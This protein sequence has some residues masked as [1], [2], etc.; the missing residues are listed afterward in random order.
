MSRAIATIARRLCALLVA[1]SVCNA[2]LAG[3]TCSVGAT[4]VNFGTYDP[5]LGS[6][7]DSTGTISV[8]CSI[9][10]PPFVE[11]VGYTVELSAGTGTYA[12]RRMQ[13]GVNQLFYNLYTDLP[14]TQI[15]GNGSG[16]TSDV[17]SSMTIGFF[18]WP[19]TRTNT[20]TLYGRIPP[21]QDIAP[22]T[23]T[24]TIVVT[25]TY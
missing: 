9:T 19:S 2:A 10:Y 1:G 24:D 7:L 5:L 15:W 13:S 22:G 6:A 16:G 3:V 20:H 21:A 25:V 14:R 4:G 18:F 23:Y 17:T 11:N 12:S 8:T